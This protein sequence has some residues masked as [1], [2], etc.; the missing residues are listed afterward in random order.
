MQVRHAIHIN[1]YINFEKVEILNNKKTKNLQ[2]YS[3][4][5]L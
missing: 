2:I 3:F 4:F 1:S 5:F